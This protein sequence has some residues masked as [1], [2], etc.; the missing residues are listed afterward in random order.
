MATALVTGLGSA[1]PSRHARMLV[2]FC[3]GVLFDTLAGAGSGQPAT[4]AELT[5]DLRELLTAMCDP[6]DRR[7]S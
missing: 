5:S 2:A 7:R 4:E 3:D 6:V 1:D